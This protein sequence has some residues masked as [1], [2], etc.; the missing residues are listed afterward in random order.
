MLPPTALP[1]DSRMQDLSSMH[2][3]TREQRPGKSTVAER[4]YAQAK[5]PLQFSE[6]RA[7]ENPLEK[8]TRVLAEEANEAAKKALSQAWSA[9]SRAGKAFGSFQSQ[10]SSGAQVWSH[11]DPL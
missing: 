5:K 6:E 4:L 2:W 7:N 1:H 3:C 8:W 10:P 11:L 9:L